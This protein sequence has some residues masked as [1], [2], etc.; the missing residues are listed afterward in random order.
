LFLPCLCSETWIVL[1]KKKNN[2]K[3]TGI[4]LT[5][6]PKSWLF[7]DTQLNNIHRHWKEKRCQWE[8]IK[9]HTILISWLLEGHFKSDH[10]S[11]PS[12]WAYSSHNPGSRLTEG[13][14]CFSRR[15]CPAY[16]MTIG[17]LPFFQMENV[18]YSYRLTSRLHS[19]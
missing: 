13:Q 5:P 6:R 7:R 1:K 4:C 18:S 16:R 15:G 17:S 19:L 2:K 12:T 14:G 10:T 11:S 9:R 3:T 8:E